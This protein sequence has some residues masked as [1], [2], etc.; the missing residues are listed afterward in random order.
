MH[1]H[2]IAT[3]TVAICTAVQTPR[4]LFINVYNVKAFDLM[5]IWI[6]ATNVRGNMVTLYMYNLTPVRGHIAECMYIPS[7]VG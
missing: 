3:P 4:T 5:N 2:N 7:V 6:T 1:Y